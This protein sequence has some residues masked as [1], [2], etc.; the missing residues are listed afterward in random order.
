M[1]EYI[2]IVYSLPGIL[3]VLLCPHSLVS[4]RSW[5]FPGL[6]NGV[7]GGGNSLSCVAA[8]P[9][10]FSPDNGAHL[11]FTGKMVTG[12]HSER[13]GWFV[14]SLKIHVEE[15]IRVPVMDGITSVSCYGPWPE[16]T[17]RKVAGPFPWNDDLSLFARKQV[18]EEGRGKMG[19]IEM[20]VSCIVFILVPCF[21]Q[22]HYLLPKSLAREG[23]VCLCV[24]CMF[25]LN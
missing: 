3:D 21:I 14:V 20:H 1:A 12:C 13:E 9:R 11:V 2:Y 6:G 16:S 10:L 24:C 19:K 5:L 4:P 17:S 18:I 22:E 7:G 25:W 23:C 15:S 8:S